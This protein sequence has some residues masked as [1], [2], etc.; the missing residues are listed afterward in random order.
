[1]TARLVQIIDLYL[2][3]ILTI[4]CI[5]LLFPKDRS[6]SLAT[7]LRM[8][9]Q[10]LLRDTERTLHIMD[11]IQ[12]KNISAALISLDAEKAFD[13]INW[14]FLYLVLKQF[15]LDDKAVECIKKHFTKDQLQG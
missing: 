2:Y 6:I 7:L 5:L 12:S 1:M 13:S 4:N 11:H 15:G 3:S 10:A 8:I 9:R 14:T